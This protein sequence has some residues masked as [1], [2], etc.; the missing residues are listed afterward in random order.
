MGDDEDQDVCPFH[1]L[2]DIR[3]LPMPVD[4]AHSV[5]GSKVWL[6]A[7]SHRREHADAVWPLLVYYMIAW[8]GECGITN[9]RQGYHMKACGSGLKIQ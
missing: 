6:W 7:T 8:P 1:S 9:T 3:L 4:C 5:W 2:A